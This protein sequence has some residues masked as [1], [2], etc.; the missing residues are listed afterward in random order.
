MNVFDYAMEMEA[1][2]RKFYLEIAA[3]SKNQGIKTIAKMLANDEQKHF[4][5]L[6]KLKEEQPVLEK[7]EILKNAKNVFAEM[8]DKIDEFIK[9]ESEIE[10]Y[11]KAQEIE[12]KSENFYLEK[13]EG[14]KENYQKE[15][16]KKIAEEEKKHYFLLENII[17]FVSRPLTWLD[18]AEFYHLDEY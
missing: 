18:D 1:D 9:P 4:N 17:Q 15:I 16:F 2:G 12:K 13:A 6:K 3:K 7:T 11:K 5:I 8:K 14:L 10:L